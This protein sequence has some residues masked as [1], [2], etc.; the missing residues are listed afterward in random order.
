[1]ATRLRYVYL[2]GVFG[3]ALFV[4]VRTLNV[5]HVALALSI[6]AIV[7]GLSIGGWVRL[8]KADPP[9]Q[10][11]E[12][13]WFLALGQVIGLLGLLVTIASPLAMGLEQGWEYIA[14][15]VPILCGA[16][17]G[18]ILFLLQRRSERLQ[19]TQGPLPVQTAAD[20]RVD[21]EQGLTTR[22]RYMYLAG[23]FL[24]VLVWC[25]LVDTLN[26]RYVVLALSIAALVFGLIIGGRA[27]LRKA[28]PPDPLLEAAWFL[29]LGQGTGLACWLPVI[30]LAYLL[31]VIGLASRLPVITSPLVPFFSGVAVGAVLFVVQR[32][33]RGLPTTQGL[34]QILTAAKRRIRLQFGLADMLSAILVLSVFLASLLTPHHLPH[35]GRIS[36][37]WTLA[38]M[39]LSTPYLMPRLPSAGRWSLWAISYLSLFIAAE[40]YGD[41]SGW[42]T[43]AAGLWGVLGGLLVLSRR[44]RKLREA[45][46]YPSP[47]AASYTAAACGFISSLL[48]SPLAV[49]IVTDVYGWRDILGVSR[50]F[51]QTGSFAVAGCVCATFGL[52]G[53]LLLLR[54][55]GIGW[56]RGV[57]LGLLVGGTV[58]GT[59]AFG[60]YTV[61]LEAARRLQ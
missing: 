17:V 60:A 31:R 54:T 52:L 21:E 56:W 33:R 23:V 5:L 6:A 10:A 3:S 1:M 39:G 35:R 58:L 49:T 16:A 14:V 25:V 4:L 46:E 59:V 2:A 40:F 11:L 27:R 42:I 24:F 57:G 45:E 29:A 61:W 53:W 26:V 15:F 20:R 37:L 18:A 44:R 43:G 34:L 41:P 32:R 51:G 48:V 36:W 9:D 28:D 55:R 30:G 12:A 50:L 47:R 7:F 13:A 8:R 22:L 19:T 38:I